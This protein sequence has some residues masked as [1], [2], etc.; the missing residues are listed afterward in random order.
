M[1]GI[2]ASTKVMESLDGR[3]SHWYEHRLEA[4]A[5]EDPEAFAM[6]AV[7]SQPVDVPVHIRGSHLNKASEPNPRAVPRVTDNVLPP[8]EI[9]ATVS[10]RL[11]LARWIVDKRNPLT[12]RV[13]VNRVWAWHF[14]QGLVRSCSDFGYRGSAPSDPALLDWLAAEFVNQGWSLKKLHRLILLSQTYRL[15]SDFSSAAT[16]IDPENR[17]HWRF[18]LRRLS[19]EQV[20]D[21]LL[22]ASGTLDLRIGGTLL[23]IAKGK[24]DDFEIPASCFDSR[25]R[26]LYLPIRRGELY[27]P[28]AAFDY[29]DANLS[30][31][32]R[33]VTVLPS[34]TLF[35]LNNP[36]VLD[37]AGAFARRLSA[38]RS[39]P[40]DRIELAYQIAFGRSPNERECAIALAFIQGDQGDATT[41][42]A[43]VWADFCHLLFCS[44]EFLY[45]RETRA[46]RSCQV[47]FPAEKC[48]ANAAWAWASS[49]WPTCSRELWRPTRA[50]LAGSFPI[51][52]PR[53]I[54]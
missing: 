13:I 38:A 37:Q 7:E 46:R 28:F 47:Q 12:A 15:S 34:Q 2:F 30:I 20:R 53:P 4:A 54:M 24:V 8:P 41:G 27:P 18:D 23:E 1:A 19:A 33:P 25:R 32:E 49:P 31:D 14:G 17:L 9:P 52:R 26:A 29:V 22:S 6:A 50:L 35:L 45:L 11:E 21:A 40:Q 39:N 36:F 43:T 10:G 42:D 48:S 44:N 5:P 16:K 51:M 3:L